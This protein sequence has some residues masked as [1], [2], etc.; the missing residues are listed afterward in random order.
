L[1][2]YELALLIKPDAYWVRYKSAQIYLKIGDVLMAKR[3]ASDLLNSP[4][5]SG[6]DRFISKVESL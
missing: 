3:M 1:K 4:N 2:F 6:K 5:F